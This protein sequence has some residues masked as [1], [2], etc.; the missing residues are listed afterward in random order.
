[1]V[2]NY[3][4]GQRI[5]AMVNCTQRS[6]TYSDSMYTRQVLKWPPLD[7]VTKV[8]MFCNR[9]MLLP[10]HVPEMTNKAADAISRNSIVAFYSHVPGAASTLMA[11]I[12]K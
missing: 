5:R 1:M 4:S 9:I 6:I 11:I 7:P 12:N 8:Y 2:T 10:I 3:Y